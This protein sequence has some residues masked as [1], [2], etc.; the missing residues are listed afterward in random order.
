V[1]SRLPHRTRRP[2]QKVRRNFRPLLRLEALE[3]RCLLSN[4]QWLVHLNG[5]PG[6]TRAVQLAAAQT[7][8]H[9]AG[10]D[11][12]GP[13]LIPVNVIN[14]VGSD[15]LVLVQTP[16]DAGQ[17]ALDAEL[18]ALP[19]YDYV[20]PYDPN[21]DPHSYRSW[22]QAPDVP[23]PADSGGP[24]PGP[25]PGGAGTGPLVAPGTGPLLPPGGPDVV[26]PVTGFNGLNSNQTN[27][28]C[29]PPD[30]IGAVGPNSYIEGVNTGYA[31]Y[32][33][34]TGGFIAGPIN[35][36]AFFA[37]LGNTRNFSDPVVQYDEIRQRFVVGM[38]DFDFVSQMRFDFAVSKS[39]DPR[40]LT[41]AD[42]NFYGY[43][44]NDGAGGYDLAD[45][46]KIGYNTQGYYVSFNMFPGVAFFDHVDVLAISASNPA[47]SQ[48][49]VVPGGFTR[50]TFAPASVHAGEAESPAYFVEDGNQGNGNTNVTVVRMD[51]PLSGTPTWT[52]TTLTVNGYARPPRAVQPGG[53]GTIDTIDARFYFS[54]LRTINGVTHL[55]AAHTVGSGGVAR[56]RWYDFDL[57]SGPA[58]TLIQEGEINP[59][60]GIYTFFPSLDINS[61]GTIGIN[62]SE[63]SAGEL[64]SMYVTGHTT[65]DAPGTVQTPKLAKAGV[66]VTND[67]RAGDYSFLNVDPTDNTTFWAA[68]EYGS[69]FPDW[70][71]WIQS[72]KVGT[73]GP[74]VI[75]Q[76][77]TS[78][79]PP[80]FNIV[81]VTFNRPVQVSTF[82][83][84]QI[85][86]FVGPTGP[87][88]GAT[89]TITPVSPTGSGLATTFTITINSPASKAGNYSFHVGPGI[90]DAQGNQMDQDGDGVPG[91]PTDFYL[92][93][94]TIT[95]P[96]IVATAPG[97]VTAPPVPSLRVT[98]DRPM[99]VSSFTA[100]KLTSFQ[101]LVGPIVTNILGDVTGITPVSPSGSPATASQ[102]DIT[103]A[104]PGEV[105]TGQYF[106]G[107]A[108]NIQDAFGNPTLAPTTVRFNVDGPK[109]LATDPSGGRSVNISSQTITFS[110]AMLVS[111]FTPDQV[112]LTGPG[113]PIAVTITPVSPS[114]GAATQFIL[115][116][117]TQTAQGTYTTTV[118]P[119][120]TDVFGNKMDQDGNFNPGEPGDQFVGTF[121][122]HAAL[123]PDVFGYTAALVAT[124]GNLEID[125]QPGTFTIIT[126]GVANDD[127]SVPVNLGATPFNFYSNTYTTIFVSSNGMISF[128]TADARYLSADLITDPNE[129]IIAPLWDDWIKPSGSDMV[130]GQFRDYVGGLPT[131]LVIEWNQVQHYP[132]SRPITFQVELSLN[133]G[134]TTSPFL[135]HYQ[136]LD[137]R[138]GSAFGGFAT[139]GIKAAGDQSGPPTILSPGGGGPRVVPGGSG[140]PG[141]PPGG[142][143]T[144]VLEVSFRQTN[145]YVQN[146]NTLL[147]S[148]P[149]FGATVSGTVFNDLNHNG[150][151]DPGEP[152]L[153][154]W[155]VFEDL[156]NN[157]IRDSGE[158]FAITD[159][160]GNYTI[161]GV[162]PGLS[163]FREELQTGYVQ[164]VPGPP[165]ALTF[166]VEG[167]H[168]YTGISFLDYAV[169][170]RVTVDNADSAFATTGPG[171]S[172]V[173]NSGAYHG[174][175]AV[176]A[177]TAVTTI[178]TDS[179][180]YSAQTANFQNLELVGDSAAFT[181]INSADD[182][183]VPVNLG[184]HTFSLY[185][186]TYTGN[187]QLFVSSNGLITFGT[188]DSDPYNSDLT[189]TPPEAA[190]APLWNDW[191]G[192]PGLITPMVLGKF[193]TVNHLLIIEWSQ[194]LHYPGVSGSGITFQAILSLDGVGDGNVVYNYGNLTGTGF[195]LYDE[196]ANATVGIKDFGFQG[197]H[198]LLVNAVGSSP[199]VGS[200]RAIRFS[201][202][203][204]AAENDSATFTV[205]TGAPGA[206]ELYAT[207]VA[208]P[209]NAPNVQYQVYDGT[210]LL[211]TATVNQQIA[212]FGAVVA[213]T[214]WWKLGR[215]TTT[216][217]TFRVVLNSNAPTVNYNL[218]ADAVFAAAAPAGSFASPVGPSIRDAAAPVASAPGDNG[219]S[220][221]GG[222]P[223]RL[224]SLVPGGPSAGGNSPAPAPTALAGADPSPL[225]RL[226]A[227]APVPIQPAP[228][229]GGLRRALLA[230]GSSLGP[231][232]GEPD[233]L[234]PT[235]PSA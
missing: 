157:G 23:T 173:T 36:D 219:A 126:A 134:G 158:P 198:R 166:N 71:T 21:A 146:G 59:G 204:V 160:S 140:G 68:N 63:S 175:Y 107:V 67:F 28:F 122:I 232:D 99:L 69:S 66:A 148:G 164:T 29:E 96:T 83:P 57:S 2:A 131:H 39:S 221:G 117:A 147:F 183:S 50:Y 192:N 77:P 3:D 112:T 33:K 121:S 48:F 161:T 235:T 58:P 80:P 46:P 213:G 127:I 108:A 13:G 169:T 76:T 224:A 17:A 10:L 185:G 165:G 197:P 32:N 156:N 102:F 65:V 54:A 84:P 116:F 141:S 209:T 133:T 162:L 64:W 9:D 31:I 139:V 16:L 124:P 190:L 217:G 191:I 193:D 41:A 53:G 1:N 111:S 114:G 179:Y 230:G 172:T 24:A 184:S 45:Y 118:G 223:L 210:T 225:D 7:L 100:P 93:T 90:K 220:G 205:A 130:E 226:F 195:S 40:T 170:P 132:S 143:L 61:A 91:E 15:G 135:F 188:A 203:P 113:G 30:T 95:S 129:P 233:D 115:G 82:T 5:L 227:S 6:D 70:S 47:T 62:Y 187:N 103:F 37:P 42:W 136:D 81:T 138:D 154:G 101:R 52:F 43:N 25:A 214:T 151:L 106:L 202:N 174:S 38:I 55:V 228:L 18:H 153:A 60:P 167:G 120:I 159:A 35:A 22:F 229:I 88:S 125:G 92:A 49:Y 94:F 215:F 20:E 171:W 234:S 75:S 72:F 196:G 26:T 206:Y 8:V 87:I 14:H 128:G 4:G 181:I 201:T 98:F 199:Y 137:T 51:N 194:V 150:L 200:G 186:T 142:I 149:S 85:T 105:L 182:L 180:G 145:P 207:W 79:V 212:P 11:S 222:S 78:P 177:S 176:H 104:S 189:N 27:C 86:S 19:G 144:D 110:R 168:T 34:T 73:G 211:G 119:N 208:L 89:F 97:G 12:P 155:T 163:T 231:W 218:E 178:G 56:A 44:V 74:A 123:G 216:S 152:G 109:V